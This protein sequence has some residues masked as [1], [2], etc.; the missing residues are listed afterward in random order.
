MIKNKNTDLIRAIKHHGCTG[1]SGDVTLETLS[2]T[3]NGEY[4]SQKG[5]A[6]N[7]VNVTVQGGGTFNINDII[8]ADDLLE[9]CQ[10]L[11]LGSGDNVDTDWTF[12]DICTQDSCGMLQAAFEDAVFAAD[13]DNPYVEKSVFIYLRNENVRVT[14]FEGECQEIDV[15][16][17]PELNIY[18]SIAYNPTTEKYNVW[19]K[20]GIS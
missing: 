11:G 8:L 5:K 3:E 19:Y 7:K 20:G 12:E 10:A 6:W 1:G 9:K 13:P 16:T 2:V 14:P 15:F 17:D 4:N 18:F